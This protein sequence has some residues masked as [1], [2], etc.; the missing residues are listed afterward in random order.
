MIFNKYIQTNYDNLCQTMK[1]VK[2]FKSFERINNK[3]NIC[4]STPLRSKLIEQH[5]QYYILN[6]FIISG[7]MDHQNQYI[8]DISY[9]F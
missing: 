5:I 1:F 8:L 3:G 7:V 6:K 2:R 4:G 9:Y